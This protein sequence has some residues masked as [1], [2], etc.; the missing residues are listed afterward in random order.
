[1][2]TAR[3]I[4]IVEK[5]AAWHAADEQ[6]NHTQHATAADALA[7]IRAADRLAAEAGR[8]TVT[9]IEWWPS[10]AIGRMVVRALQA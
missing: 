8:S 2:T 3:T 6:G 4:T 10:T 7:S 9:T 5:S 1:M